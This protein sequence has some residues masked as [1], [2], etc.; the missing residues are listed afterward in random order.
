MRRASPLSQPGEEERWL[1]RKTHLS[2][3]HLDGSKNVVGVA[4]AVQGRQVAVIWGNTRAPQEHRTKNI[5]SAL[6]PRADEGFDA[7]RVCASSPRPVAAHPRPGYRRR[8][9]RVRSISP[10]GGAARS[11]LANRAAGYSKYAKRQTDRQTRRTHG[12]AQNR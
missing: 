1:S 11:E 12:S 5:K 2:A 8:P 10:H 4:D 7:Y 3:F 6:R 9:P